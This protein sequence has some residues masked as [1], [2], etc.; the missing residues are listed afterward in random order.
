MGRVIKLRPKY[1]GA[2][3]RYRVVGNMIYRNLAI[4]RYS[5]AT[6]ISL[7]FRATCLQKYFGLLLQ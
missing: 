5:R 3:L 4:Q 7:S 6:R 2:A 1:T